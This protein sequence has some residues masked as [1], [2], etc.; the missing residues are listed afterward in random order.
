MVPLVGHIYSDGTDG[1]GEILQETSNFCQSLMTSPTNSQ[2][3]ISLP[4]E[5]QEFPRKRPR[6]RK[7]AW[8]IEVRFL[9]EAVSSLPE[10]SARIEDLV[11]VETGKGG[12]VYARPAGFYAGAKTKYR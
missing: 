9:Y 12:A 10:T 11:K 5:S 3:V 7:L 4:S 1:T 8:E 2:H 6:K